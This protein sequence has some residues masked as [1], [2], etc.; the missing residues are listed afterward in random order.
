MTEAESWTIGRLLTWT[1]EFLKA[2]G[3]DAPRLDAEVLL[4]N[5]RRC[6]R[7][8]LYTAFDEPA[9]T[10]TRNV[11]RDLVQ[12]RVAGTPVAYLVGEKEFYSLSFQVT[13]DVLIPRP[14]TEL[15]VVTLLD[16]IGDRGGQDP[17]AIADIGTG[18]GVLAVCAAKHCARCHVT[19]IDVSP[20]ALAVATVNAQRHG[21]DDR[22]E[23]VESDLFTALPTAQTFDFIASNPPYVA[24][25]EFAELASDIRDNEPRGALVAGQHGTE[26]FAR[27]IP[28]SQS[29]LRRGGWLLLEIAPHQEEAVCQMIDQCGGFAAPSVV[30]DLAGHARVVHAELPA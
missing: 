6:A 12:Q 20:Q 23:W 19:A 10:E 27:L 8:E 22:I 28:A 2:R 9:S 13:P 11:F 14:E 21:V 1:T 29:R 18:S 25:A 5:A 30:K 4:A 24:A 3:V 17:I 15:V 7:I 16:R 26:V